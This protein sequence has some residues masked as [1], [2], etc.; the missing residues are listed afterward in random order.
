MNCVSPRYNQNGWLGVRNQWSAYQLL[1][2]FPR[3]WHF[4]SCGI[5][6]SWAFWLMTFIWLFSFF[7]TL[8]MSCSLR[9][10]L[11]S[12]HSFNASPFF[13]HLCMSPMSKWSFLLS[14]A[15]SKR[16]EYGM[17]TS[18]LS[19]FACVLFWMNDTVGLIHSH[20]S[21][22][23]VMCLVLSSLVK[24]L[25]AARLTFRLYVSMKWKLKK[26][27]MYDF[28]GSCFHVQ[29]K[30]VF[31]ISF[32]MNDWFLSFFVSLVGG[33]SLVPPNGM[34]VVWDPCGDRRSITVCRC[35]EN[36]SVHFGQMTVRGSAH[37]RRWCQYHYWSRYVA[38][39]G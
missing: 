27:I 39:R 34:K 22:L 38:C 10:G 7:S 20:L 23:S 14:C 31:F 5:V 4:C 29:H 9:L 28:N 33:T 24:W 6:H 13:A 2:L 8:R 12:I 32:T 30:L 36:A 1:A 11:S 37:T 15:T 3:Q 17:G 18:L 19:H 35:G 26:N 25:A 21:R 16:T